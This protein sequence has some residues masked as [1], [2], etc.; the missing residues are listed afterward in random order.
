M[1]WY[2]IALLVLWAALFFAFYYFASSKIV[3]R[4]NGG[5][6]LAITF[7]IAAGAIGLIA[8]EP[9]PKAREVRKERTHKEPRGSDVEQM[10]AT[11]AV[12]Q[13]SAYL[14]SQLRDPGSYESISW[15]ELETNSHGNYGIIHKYRAKNGF[16]GYDVMSQYFELDKRG[17][18]VSV[19]DLSR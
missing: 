13:V 11:G 1:T 9:E 19:T 4:A 16:G 10:S 7:F 5:W 18:V 3:D 14:K 2:I 12:W 15:G 8:P 17:Y 6:V